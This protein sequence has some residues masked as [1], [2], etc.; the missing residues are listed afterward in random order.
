MPDRITVAVIGAGNVRCTP[1]VLATL[2]SYFGERPLNIVLYDADA[3]RL[4]LFDRLARTFLAFTRS[5]NM[6]SSTED[7]DEALATADRVIVQLDDNGARKLLKLT[8]RASLKM[9]A[10]LK[11]ALSNLSPVAEVLS[12]MPEGVE[13]PLSRYRTMLWPF[14]DKSFEEVAVPHQALRWIHGEEYPF[15][16]FAEHEDSPLKAWLNDPAS[17]LLAERGG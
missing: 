12:L 17:A 10:A 16:F 6:L 5:T 8:R 13:L 1:Q 7:P 2:A 15:D 14:L 9:D 3:E 4:D 11:K